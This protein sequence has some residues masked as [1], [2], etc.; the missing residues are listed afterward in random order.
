MRRGSSSYVVRC[1]DAWVSW[2]GG[3]VHQVL[4]FV[5]ES[6]QKPFNPSPGSLW[7]CRQHWREE[8]Q[9]HCLAGSPLSCP[10][11][12]LASCPLSS[13]SLRGSSSQQRGSA[14]VWQR[15]CRALWRCT[16][17]VHS[18]VL[19]VCS[20][21]GVPWWHLQLSVACT[22]KTF[23]TICSKMC[24]WTVALLASPPLEAAEAQNVAGPEAV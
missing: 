5:C 4:V 13:S 23:S 22:L 19:R 1:R 10:L 2:H 7:A 9:P 11:P 18:R 20:S 16:G 14:L 21:F 12:C 6:K 8:L 15:R 3:T 17:S 24:V